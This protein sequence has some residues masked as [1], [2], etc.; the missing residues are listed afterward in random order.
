MP[1]KK[2]QKGKSSARKKTAKSVKKKKASGVKKTVSR[3]K[4][5]VKAKSSGKTA[6]K[7]STSTK[8]KA[9][10]KKKPVKK[11]SSKKKSGGVKKKA[12]GRRKA[13][14][15]KASTVRKKTVSRKKTAKKAAPA[16][17]KASP[18]SRKS[19]AASNSKP[20]RTAKRAKKP[21][22]KKELKE[23][24]M[25]LLN[26]RDKVVDDISFLKG[27]NLNHSAR[28][29]TGDLSGYSIHMADQGTDNFDREFALN[30]VSSEHDILYEIDEALRRIDNGTFGICEHTGEPIEKERLKVIP[31]T[32]YSVTAQQ[33]M[34]KGRARYRPFG[35]TLSSGGLN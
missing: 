8:K 29:S 28:D 13:T 31:H 12:A 32:R 3:K 16:R 1:N 2:S 33:E 6:G 20:K 22:S 18:K 4:T 10:G 14:V 11:V 34:E 30:M 17:V 9:A 19:T 26:I 24:R 7:K 35:P 5:S 27:D 21:F 25:L 15:S 23:F